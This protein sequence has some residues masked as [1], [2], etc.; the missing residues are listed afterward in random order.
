MGWGQEAKPLAPFFYNKWE[1][2]LALLSVISIYSFHHP[3]LSEVWFNDFNGIPFNLYSTFLALNQC[4]LG[5]I[6]FRGKSLN[7]WICHNKCYNAEGKQAIFYRKTLE[8]VI[9]KRPSRVRQ[10]F[11]SIM[12]SIIAM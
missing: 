5:G 4:L 1:L 9:K 7:L 6:P 2:P 12:Q 8:I 3:A 10:P 11:Y